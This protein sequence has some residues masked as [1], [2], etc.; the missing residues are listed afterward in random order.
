MTLGCL[1]LLI[2]QIWRSGTAPKQALPAVGFCLGVLSYLLV[3]WEPMQEYY[4]FFPLLALTFAN[5]FFFWLF[6]KSLFDDGFSFKKWMPWALAVV[7]VFFYIAFFANRMDGFGLPENAKTVLSMGQQ[8][9]ALLFVVLAIVEASRNRESDLVL[10]R[11]HFRNAFILCAAVL[12]TLTILSEI[13]FKNGD[14]PLWMEFLQKAVIAGLTFYF[15]FHR[16]E[17]KTGFFVEAVLEEIPTPKPNIDHQ[18]AD[19]LISLIEGEKYYRTEGLTIR[20][21]SEKLDVKEYRLRQT[22]NQHLG[23]RNFNDFLNSYRIQEACDLI[24]DPKRK[25]FT[26]LEIAFEMGYNSLA[27][28]NKAFKDTTGMTPTDWRKQKPNR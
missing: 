15:A 4:L 25:D 2:V 7:I 26:I 10:S 6:S 22:I 21:L 12:I 1:S 23:F 18:L 17:F 11:L 9:I 28:F 27:P 16:L 19:Q 14:A 20:Q 5:P 13:A 3:D 8:A 24:A